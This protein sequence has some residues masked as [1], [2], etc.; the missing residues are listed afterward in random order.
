MG[1]EHL[2]AAGERPSSAFLS[3]RAQAT[4]DAVGLSSAASDAVGLP[5]AA[6]PLV[7]SALPFP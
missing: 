4:A 3:H 5:S 1:V 7:L 2:K 6:F